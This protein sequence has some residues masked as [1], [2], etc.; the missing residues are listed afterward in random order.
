M[1]GTLGFA[2][3]EAQGSRFWFEIEMSAASPLSND[4]GSLKNKRTDSVKLKARVAIA[5]DN[6]VNR[7]IALAYLEQ[8]GVEA[9]AVKN[10]REL[11]DLIGR[12]SFDLILMDCQMPGMDGYAATRAIRASNQAGGRRIPIVAMTAHA[13]V[14]DRERC[15]AAGMDEY[16]AKPFSPEELEGVLRKFT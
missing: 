14:G 13:L 8:I 9:T 15:L 7:T 6:S 10:G 2:S 11:L 1:G 5:E 4:T 12:E 3:E 16:I